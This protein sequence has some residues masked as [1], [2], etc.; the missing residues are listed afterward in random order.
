MSLDIVPAPSLS[1]PRCDKGE[2]NPFPIVR[3]LH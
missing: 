1:L 2:D 3:A